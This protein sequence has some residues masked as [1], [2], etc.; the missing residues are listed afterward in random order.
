MQK[1]A[2]D[3]LR[4]QLEGQLQDKEVA[5]ARPATDA[6][7]RGACSQLLFASNSRWRS[8]Q[9]EIETLRVRHS[10]E[11]LDLKST[12]AER[13]DR[14]AEVRENALALEADINTVRALCA[15]D[16]AADAIEQRH[17]G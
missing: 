10:K 15:P 17:R 14:L 2:L 12:I 16:S 4:L 13:D 3:A 6:V 9:A 5:G 7:G 11:V 8:A 1:D